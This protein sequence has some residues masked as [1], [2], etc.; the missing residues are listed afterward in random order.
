MAPT[1]STEEGE[2]RQSWGAR[3]FPVQN[4]TGIPMWTK[5]NGAIDTS[6]NA[7]LRV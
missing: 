4:Q 7:L 3:Q 2:E 5:E 6:F 1:Y